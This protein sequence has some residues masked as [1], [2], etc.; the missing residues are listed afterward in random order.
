LCKTCLLKLVIEGK[1]DGRIEVM[2][3][4]RRRR[5]QILDELTEGRGYC[6][7]KEEEL[8]LLAGRNGFLRGYEPAVRRT[9]T[10]SRTKSFKC[11]NL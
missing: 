4:R 11:T 3:R 7:F 8:D 5:K 9:T 6:K 1:V 2:E 10:S